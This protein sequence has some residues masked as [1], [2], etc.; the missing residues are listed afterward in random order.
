MFCDGLTIFTFWRALR[1][2]KR[3]DPPFTTSPAIPHIRC[4]VQATTIVFAQVCNRSFD[5]ALRLGFILN[6]AL[7]YY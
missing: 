5:Y 1:F 6:Q 2:H 4:P 7:G 3:I